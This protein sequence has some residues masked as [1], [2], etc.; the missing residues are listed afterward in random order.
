[1]KCIYPIKAHLKKPQ[2]LT[3]KKKLVSYSDA[4]LEFFSVICSVKLPG[5][6]YLF[7]AAT[8]ATL[9]KMNSSKNLPQFLVV[10]LSS[11]WPWNRINLNQAYNL[12]VTLPLRGCFV[13]QKEECCVVQCL[14]D[15]AAR[16]RR[17]RTTVDSSFNKRQ[18]LL[19]RY[20]QKNGWLNPVRHCR[21]RSTRIFLS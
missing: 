17:R 3:M 4:G 21:L 12:D 1:M 10:D 11:K 7:D 9:R 6:F 20:F 13:W 5:W 14:A 15:G 16:R 2:K 8:P 18:L 19:A